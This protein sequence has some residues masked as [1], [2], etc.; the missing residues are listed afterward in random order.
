MPSTAEYSIVPPAIAPPPAPNATRPIPSHQPAPPAYSP[1][2]LVSISTPHLPPA[3]HAPALRATVKP[4]P[5]RSTQTWSALTAKTYTTLPPQ[6]T[7]FPVA[8]ES[9]IAFSVPVQ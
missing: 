7:A 2:P 3:N 8:V 4:A 6:A 9:A 1:A 5:F